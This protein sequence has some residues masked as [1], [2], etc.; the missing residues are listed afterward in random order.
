MK[1]KDV[2]SK[3]KKVIFLDIDGTIYSEFGVIPESARAAIRMAREQGHS[4][5]LNTGRNRGE[6]P[7]D[8]I[9]L[10][11]DGIVGSSGAYA[12][13]AGNVIFNQHMEKTLLNKI[14]D[15][16]FAHEIAFTAETNDK[17]Y[18]TKENIEEQVRVFREFA[19]THI[20]DF[21]KNLDKISIFA[22][23]LMETENIYELEGVN[24]IIFYH[25]SFTIEELREKL[26]EEVMVISSTIGFMDGIS[27]EIYSRDTNKATGMEAIMRHVGCVREDTI[28]FGDAGNDLEM[29]AFAGVG[30]AMG[31][32]TSEAK[33][34]ADYVTGHVKED[35]LYQGFAKFGLL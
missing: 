31:N 33:A 6:I 2:K 3:N 18:G 23:L 21:E 5:F 15:F 11:F 28:A 19:K 1:N 29:L 10:G 20:S 7:G 27:G 30:V 9:E 13:V 24:K 26:G 8:I 12:E 14:Y 32:G 22:N 4:L 34:A 16:L 35:G 25:S 17:I